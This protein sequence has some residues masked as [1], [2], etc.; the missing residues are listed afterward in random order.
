MPTASV[1][2]GVLKPDHV[3]VRELEGEAILLNLETETYFGLDE[4]ATRMWAALAA[5]GS[6]ER[7]C[8]LLEQEF[9]VEPDRLRSD[10]RQLVDE[11][12]ESGL[13][14][15]RAGDAT[16]QP[17]PYSRDHRESGCLEGEGVT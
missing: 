4:V 12:V 11:L 10:V 16:S 7:A 15:L 13:L 1:E 14:A 8:E 9:A 17:L 2:C 3:V 5:S 6:I